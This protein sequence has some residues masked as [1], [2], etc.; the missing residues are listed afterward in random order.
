V[1]LGYKNKVQ[2]GQAQIFSP[3]GTG[4]LQRKYTL[5]NTPGLVKDRPERYEDKLTLQ[6]SP[7]DQAEPSAVPPIVHEVL[8]SPGQSLDVAT[9]A[10]MEPRF[11]HDF[12]RVRV[13][14]NAKAAESARAVNAQAYTVGSDIVFGVGQYISETKQGIHLRDQAR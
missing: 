5:S 10:H 12:S 14:T 1:S 7:V 13:H 11:G 6:R 8:R 2:A 3:V 9:R 4:L